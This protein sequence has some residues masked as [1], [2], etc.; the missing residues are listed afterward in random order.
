MRTMN[1]YPDSFGAKRASVFPHR[2]PTTY[3]VIDENVAPILAGGGDLVYA[4]EAGM[5][6][7]DHVM[8]GSSDSGTYFVQVIPTTVSGI[9]ATPGAIPQPGTSARLKWLVAAT[10]AEA[11]AVDL[12]AEIV[13]LFAVGPQ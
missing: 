8:G 13:R 7:F 4:N 10:G 2:G 12:S 11:A 1:G 3:V 6:Y 5:K 9:V